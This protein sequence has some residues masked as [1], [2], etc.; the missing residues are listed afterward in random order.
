MH[1]PA[2]PNTSSREALKS[3]LVGGKGLHTKQGPP[4]RG[5]G[6]GCTGVGGSKD[7]G[8]E[9]L[10][11]GGGGQRLQLGDAGSSTAPQGHPTLGNTWAPNRGAAGDTVAPP[12]QE[13]RELPSIGDSPK[14]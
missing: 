9:V 7:K 1:S 12:S 5:Q 10:G 8:R 3:D 6:S 11:R 2:Y 13:K 4:A 14:H